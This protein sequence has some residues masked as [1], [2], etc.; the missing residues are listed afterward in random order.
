MDDAPV[1]AAPEPST[2]V[3]SAVV[4]SPKGRGARK[5]RRT[6]AIATSLVLVGG[7][8]VVAKSLAGSGGDGGASS[9]EAAVRQLV[10]AIADTDVLGMVD[11]VAPSE[12]D[13]LRQ[14]MIDSI[15]ELKRI[16]L[17]SKDFSL[18]KVPGAKVQ[19]SDLE[20]ETNELTDDIAAVRITGGRLKGSVN[21]AAVAGSA[22]P[23]APDESSDGSADLG[24]SNIELATVKEG[25]SWYVSLWYSVAFAA[26]GGAENAPTFGQG[27]AARGA[28][29]PEAA[30]RSMV[31][32]VG[33]LNMRRA[34]EL[35]APD[36]A[37]ALHDYA[38][39]FLPEVEEAAAGT[40]D[41]GFEM[42]VIML[43]M[44]TKIDGDRARVSVDNFEIEAGTRDDKVHMVQKDGCTVIETNG[45]TLDSCRDGRKPQGKQ[46]V[47]TVKRDGKWYISPTASIAEQLLAALR[48]VSDNAIDDLQNSLSGLLG[49]FGG[50]GAM[51]DDP[52]FD[53]PTPAP[54]S[55]FA[56]IPSVSTGSGARPAGI[57]S[58]S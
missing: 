44:S 28:D 15:G 39:K 45:D 11:A 37:R 20:V 58:G 14:P 49:G 5:G 42:N 6:A 32:A 18:N 21:A 24:D 36:E 54:A 9:P 57:S 13:P 31:D 29:S 10:D 19:V 41:D 47:A 56:P 34:I 3:D 33:D 35:L 22:M 16:G 27:V 55:T 43:E 4:D 38:P 23:D 46:Y 17:V 12:R 7:S 52:T 51:P 50:F 26:T 2:L 8:L 30:V 25:G 48:T 1:W 53:P 40:K